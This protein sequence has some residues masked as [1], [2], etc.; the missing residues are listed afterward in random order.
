MEPPKAGLQSLF[1]QEA[2]VDAGW[3][4]GHLCFDAV[5]VCVRQQ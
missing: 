5:C 2:D 3:V 4:G 1:A